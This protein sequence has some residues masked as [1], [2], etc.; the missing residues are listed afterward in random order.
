MRTKLFVAVSLLFAF[1]FGQTSWAG[2]TASQAFA[3]KHVTVSAAR[4]GKPSAV[5]FILTNKRGPAMWVTA[6]TS[7]LS[8]S[9]MMDYDA[10]MTLSSSHM[11]ATPSVEVRSGKSVVFSY[12]GQGAMLGSVSKTLKVGSLVK[13]T[14]AWHSSAYPITQYQTVQALVVKAKPKIYFG[15]SSDGSMPGMNMG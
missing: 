5:S 3:F 1:V 6:V 2:A 8:N 7:P 15:G 4:R 12:E 9:A 14:V 13:I 10:N 11:V